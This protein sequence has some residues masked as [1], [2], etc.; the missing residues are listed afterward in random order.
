MIHR[1]LVAA[2]LLLGATSHARAQELDLPPEYRQFMDAARNAEAIN[3]PLQR[4]LAYPD[5]PGNTWT[6]GMARKASEFFDTPSPISLG[7]IDLMLQ[8]RGGAKQV[9]ALYRKELD[10]SFHG[11][12][13]RVFRAFSPFGSCCIDNAERTARAWLAASPDSPYART[14]LGLVLAERGWKARGTALARATPASNFVQMQAFFD[15]AIAQF[16]AALKA[17]PRMLPACSKMI[18]IG[19]QTSGELQA[20][21]ISRCLEADPASYYVVAQMASAAEPKWGGS[22]AQMRAVADYAQSQMRVNPMLALLS[23]APQGEGM[24]VEDPAAIIASY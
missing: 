16:D 17:E 10:A 9:D 2:C 5:L 22:P 1:L 4:C 19:A 12:H 3:D 11:E 6:P 23:I 18:S 7:A 24:L 13:D 8:A 14:A 20:R 15:G 21:G